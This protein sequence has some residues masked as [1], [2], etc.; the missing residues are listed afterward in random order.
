M[1]LSDTL[2]D[3]TGE[4]YLSVLKRLHMVL[5][6]KSY[7]EIGVHEGKSIALAD[8]PSIGVDPW[9]RLESSVVGKKPLCALYQLTSDDF[10]ASVNPINIFGRQIDFAFLDGLHFCEYLLRDF[11]NTEKYCKPNSVIAIH[12]CLPLDHVM[13]QRNDISRTP[14]IATRSGWWTGD[15]WRCAVV[16]KRRRADLRF[17][18][19]DA[20]PT[21]LLLVTNL[22]PGSN[23]NYA[24]LVSEM[25]HLN[26]DLRAMHKELDVQPTS[27]LDEEQKIAARFWL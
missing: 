24:D 12:D 23:I 14:A 25:Q 3:F 19:L 17:T 9:F 4:H 15:I 7:L 18:A 21:G 5:K 6:P 20:P 11:I 13:A 8:C 27:I 26:I 2:P 22:K 16:L 1:D 10:F